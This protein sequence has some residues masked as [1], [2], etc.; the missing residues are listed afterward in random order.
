MSRCITLLYIRTFLVVANFVIWQLWTFQYNINSDT[1]GTTSIHSIN[2]MAIQKTHAPKHACAR[3]DFHSF[4]HFLLLQCSLVNTKKIN[5]IQK[6]FSTLLNLVKTY[7][8]IY[9][10]LPALQNLLRSNG[11]L[12]RTSA[13]IFFFV[14]CTGNA[15]KDLGLSLAIFCVAEV[16]GSDGDHWTDGNVS[17]LLG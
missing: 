11:H 15:Q 17:E 1:P 2:D 13:H 9:R 14:A 7:Y 12:T 5:K 10:K 3:E 8:Q 4:C 16:T 6:N